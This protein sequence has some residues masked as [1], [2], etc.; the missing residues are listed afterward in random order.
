MR[1]PRDRR[2]TY[3]FLE[4]ARESAPVLLDT[5]IDMTSI[6]HQRVLHK[7]QGVN[8][9]YISYLIKVI[10]EVVAKYP[11]ANSSVKAALIPG[12]VLY[13]RVVAKFTLDKTGFGERLVLAA[14][15]KDSDKK[16]IEEIQ[17]DI[18]HYK[19][20]D[21]EDSEAFA[22]VR[23]LNSLPFIL[24]RWL[25][26]FVLGKLYKRQ[27]IQGSFTVTSLGHSR[28]N[29]F[30]PISSTTLAFGVGAIKDSV[31]VVDGEM[32]VRPMMR[33]SMVFDHRAIDGALAA[34]I[35]NDIGDG[36]ERY[37]V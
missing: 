19:A 5:D 11:Q 32:L 7:E 28:V 16:S 22:A 37:G 9:S 6:R 25:Y 18:D 17:K 26:G 31:V 20:A 24:G 4:R 2:H 8:A 30:F 3:F 33:L 12:I 14:L 1:Y 35:L 10:S 13:D 34:D 27:E 29:G 23:K 15:S 36:M 21:Y